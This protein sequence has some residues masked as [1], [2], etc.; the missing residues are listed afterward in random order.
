MQISIEFVPKKVG[1]HDE[2]LTIHY[3]TGKLQLIISIQIGFVANTI[4]GHKYILT[5]Y[6]YRT[7]SFSAGEEVYV[8][9]YGSSIDVNVRLDRS[10][11]MLDNTY[12]GLSSQ[13]SAIIH[14]RSNVVVHYQWKAFASEMEENMKRERWRE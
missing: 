14:N 4:I 1:D 5:Y 10:S 7:L 3:D 13:R 6:R 2:E 9:L 11:L 8:Q 12:L